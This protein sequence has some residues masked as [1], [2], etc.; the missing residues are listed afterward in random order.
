MSEPL[1]RPWGIVTP[2]FWATPAPGAAAAPH[3]LPSEALRARLIR[4]AEVAQDGSLEDAAALAVQLDRD[5]TGEY[6]SARSCGTNVSG[7]R[8]ASLSAANSRLAAV[9]P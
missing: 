9:L 2:E 4:V 6:I 7:S 8:S 3:G 5:V 1:Y